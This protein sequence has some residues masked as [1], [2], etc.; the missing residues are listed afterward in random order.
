MLVTR[1]NGVGT[2]LGTTGAEGSSTAHALDAYLA[3]LFYLSPRGTANAVE[4]A[5][6]SP[7]ICTT[8]VV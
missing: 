7:L 2:S 4:K 8:S 5:A 6:R 3:R 1:R